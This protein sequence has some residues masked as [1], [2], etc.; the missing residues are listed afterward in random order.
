MPT[1]DITERA[2]IRKLL[3]N[4]D[5]VK[6]W[7]G[8]VASEFAGQVTNLVLPLIAV[9]ALGAG[10][11][12]VA[13]LKYLPALVDRADLGTGN[14]LLETSRSAAFLGGPALGGGLVQALTAPFALVAGVVAYLAA[15]VTFW[16]IKTREEPTGVPHG[17]PRATLRGIG[18]GLRVVFA[19]PALRTNALMAGL[20]NF[21]FFAFTTVYVV[22]L[23]RTLNLTAG[24]IG[25]VMAGIGP[26]LLAGSI[27]ALHLPHR[28]GYG[29]S[30]LLSAFFANASMLFVASLHGSGWLTVAALAGLNFLQ[31]MFGTVNN[32][33]MLTLRQAITPDTMLGRVAASVRFVAQGASPLGAVVG[34]LLATAVGLRVAVALGA[35]LLMLGFVVLALSPLARIGKDL[36]ALEPAA[37]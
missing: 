30:L 33:T 20:F 28:L 23:A 6:L 25:L 26:G 8:Q 2:P 19:D 15:A 35:G 9:L 12:A 24:Q 27:L 16:R 37:R 18:E 29:R 17:G 4:R 31:A 7:S 13:T 5:F 1:A 11:G 3:R 34:G 36:S 32:I 21:G 22:F 14:S 10:A